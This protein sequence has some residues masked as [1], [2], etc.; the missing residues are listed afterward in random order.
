[1]FFVFL[2]PSLPENNCRE[3]S[4]MSERG[5]MIEEGDK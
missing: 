1:M 4:G 3:K 5:A 2:P